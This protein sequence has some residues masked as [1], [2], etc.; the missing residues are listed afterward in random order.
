MVDL[1]DLG[2]IRLCAGFPLKTFI[3]SIKAKQGHSLHLTAETPPSHLTRTSVVPFEMKIEKG[4][5]LLRQTDA[6][7]YDSSSCPDEWL[8]HTH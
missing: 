6:Q 8:S 3:F 7:P 5:F 1:V 4:I 2:L